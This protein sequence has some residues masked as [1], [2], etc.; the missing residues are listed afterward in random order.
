MLV[1]SRFSGEKIVCC[2][3][4]GEQI[5]FTLLHAHNGRVRIGVTAPPEITVDR[6]ELLRKKLLV[7]LQQ[8]G[9]GSVPSKN[10][11]DIGCPQHPAIDLLG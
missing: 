11:G 6:E 1:L 5:V 7:P 4:S 9:F 3:A 10:C 2:T 8:M